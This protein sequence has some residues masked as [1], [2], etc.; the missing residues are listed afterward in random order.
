MSIRYQLPWAHQSSTLDGALSGDGCRS[1]WGCVQASIGD[2][3]WRV[4][5]LLGSA[6]PVLVSGSRWWPVRRLLAPLVAVLRSRCPLGGFGRRTFALQCP[7]LSGGRERGHDD[8]RRAAS[9]AVCGPRNAQERTRERCFVGL[10]VALTGHLCRCDAR[11]IRSDGVSVSSFGRLWPRVRERSWGFVALGPMT[12]RSSRSV[13][14]AVVYGTSGG[15]GTNTV[16]VPL[17]TLA[18]DGHGGLVDCDSGA[19]EVLG[20]SLD[21][22]GWAAG[23][24]SA[25]G[26]ECAGS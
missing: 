21:K 12:T 25:I 11:V 3:Q 13:P 24:R 26:G 5:G 4:R 2:G 14:A 7:P 8:G 23:C 1:C 19:F 20:Q 10:P 22:P 6:V 16:A 9:G 15:A 17:A 18:R